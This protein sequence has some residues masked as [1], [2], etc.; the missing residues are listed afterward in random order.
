MV[1]RMKG[2]RLSQTVLR[3][4]AA[5]ACVSMKAEISMQCA[6]I[7][8]SAAGFHRFGH[9]SATTFCVSA[10]SLSPAKAS[11]SFKGA[12]ESLQWS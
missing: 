7:A 11:Q 1:W 6:G 10:A 2:A 5:A 4:Q 9:N 12:A 8:P 3:W